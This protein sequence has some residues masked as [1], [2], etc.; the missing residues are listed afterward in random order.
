MWKRVKN[1]LDSGI[2]KIKWF[3][4]LL[5]ERVRIE[6]SL[7]KLFYRSSEMEKERASLMKTIGE[8][9]YEL[10][11]GPGKHSIKDE[12]ITETIKKAETLDAEIEDMR[13]KIS[14][15]GGSET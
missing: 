8:R 1:N 13:K 4:S 15:I 11:R 9:V 5:N 6:I 14:D 12:L 7:F 10:R 2:E 3:S